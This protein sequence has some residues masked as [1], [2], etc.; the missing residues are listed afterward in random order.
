[1]PATIAEEHWPDHPPI[2]AAPGRRPWAAADIAP[3]HVDP[4]GRTENWWFPYP[5]R[6]GCNSKG[7]CGIPGRMRRFPVTVITD[8]RKPKRKCC[9]T[10]QSNLREVLLEGD[11]NAW[12]AV[13]LGADSYVRGGC[14]R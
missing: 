3:N 10:V 12:S 14:A 4:W 1:M 11:E 7:V 2:L 9:H 5:E 8:M 13:W 6:W